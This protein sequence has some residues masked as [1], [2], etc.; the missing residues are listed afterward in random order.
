M[1]SSPDPISTTPKWQSA[2]VDQ[3][4]DPLLSGYQ[5]VQ[6]YQGAFGFQGVNPSQ[7]VQAPAQTL[8]APVQQSGKSPQQQPSVEGQQDPAIGLP[9][10]PLNENGYMSATNT[11][12]AQP[13]PVDPVRQGGKSPQ[14]GGS[15]QHQ[16]AMGGDYQSD[17]AM[18]RMRTDRRNFGGADFNQAQNMLQGHP[19]YDQFSQ[20]MGGKSPQIG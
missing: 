11:F 13:S 15:F 2:K 19:M 16:R 4:A 7:P 10:A 20:A 18:N 1:G 14:R 8:Q 17:D 3:N 5:P 9:P 6:N 12:A